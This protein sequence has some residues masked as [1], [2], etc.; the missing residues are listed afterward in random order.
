[1]LIGDAGVAESPDGSLTGRY[2]FL[3]ALY[4]HVLYEG[5]GAAR[6]MR[7]HRAIGLHEEGNGEPGRAA[8]LAMHF[9]RA[10]D[11]ARA[12]T[13]HELAGRAALERHAAHEAAGH[14]GA[15]LDALAHQPALPDRAER[16]LDLVLSRATLYM[17]TRG[18][19]APETEREFTHARA[20]CDGLRASPKVPPV[21]RG[22]LSY[23]QVRAELAAADDLG[24][25]LLRHAE[26]SGADPALRVQ[27]H[28]GHGVTLYHLGTLDAARAH[29][30][31][32]LAAYDPATHGEHIRVYGGYD[33]GVACSMWLGWTLALMGRLEEAAI[34]E[35]ESVDLARRLGQPFSLAWAYCG[36]STF[37]LIF[38]DYIAS[39]TAAADAERLAE[40][41]GFPYVLGMAMANRGWAVIRQGDPAAG[42]PILRDGVA[43]IDATGAALV[44]PQYLGMLAAADA[45][46]GR[47]EA[48]AARTDE[49][50]A[51]MERTGQRLHEVQLLIGKSRLLPGNDAE[52][53]A[54][55]R[56][57]LEVARLQDARLLELRAAVELARHRRQR[58]HV[59]EAHAVLAEAHA[60]FRD[61]PATTP[62]LVAAR[63]LLAELDAA[64]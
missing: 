54:Q 63:R 32:A 15:A 61:Q 18:Y 48:A 60:W 50:L 20:L 21:L 23:R 51:E 59:A 12:L 57:A 52:V 14:I 4:R 16:E 22:L 40:E 47:F 35:R 1:M 28:Y 53:D 36:A 3:H 44:R 5:I 17:T 7:L 27:A 62:D 58:G 11:H 24:A 55:L 41:H 56:R 38:G 10:G 33:P 9:E 64:S 2:R 31:Q 34:R 29:L 19:G 8:E 30:E 13:Y 42:I 39:A 26:S 6:R 25:L 49:A 43:A 37:E 46:E 45:I